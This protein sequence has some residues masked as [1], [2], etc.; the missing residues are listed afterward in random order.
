MARLVVIAIAVVLAAVLLALVVDV[1]RAHVRPRLSRLAPRM[2]PT[3]KPR[4][5]DWERRTDQL[6]RPAKA[7]PGPREYRDRIVVFLESRSGV[8]AYME[9]RTVIN[10]LS[11]MLVAEDGE[12]I[13]VELRD[14]AFLRELSRSRGLAIHDAMRTGYPE[15]MRRHRRPDAGLGP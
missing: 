12:W 2:R 11:L 6:Y 3:P 9:P 1:L 8:E 4:D 10:P 13:R 7:V 5:Y 15:R 14:D